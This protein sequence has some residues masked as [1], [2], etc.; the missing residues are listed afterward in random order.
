MEETLPGTERIANLAPKLSPSSTALG[1]LLR[2]LR[3]EE[4]E[5][6]QLSEIVESDPV[7]AGNV[8]QAA[9]SGVYGRSMRIVSI[10]RA[11]ALLG[12]RRVQNIALALSVVRLWDQIKY[13][14][15]WSQR[16]FAQ[17]S[18]ATAMFCDLLAQTL[19]T[20]NAE[21]AFIAG[22]LHGL[23]KLAFVILCPKEIVPKDPPMDDRVIQEYF[24][25]IQTEV[26]GCSFADA[27]MILAAQWN[28]P[29]EI[30][31]AM[32]PPYSRPV[33]VQGTYSLG[34]I[35]SLG[36]EVV[37]QMGLSYL[38]CHPEKAEPVEPLVEELGVEH[39]QEMIAGFKESFQSINWA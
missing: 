10:P 31:A 12:M 19:P 7:L 15:W 25:E 33:K 36:H 16:K 3:E 28:L 6:R 20:K 14:W 27:G 26:L 18:L 34:Q 17:H 23:G 24:E 30:Q 39:P 37:G 2:A 1:K 21:G 11:I 13:P 38:M 8:L 32:I 5:F 9:N 29:A 22:L 4:L 35:L